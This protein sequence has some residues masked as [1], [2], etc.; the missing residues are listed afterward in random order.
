MDFCSWKTLSSMATPVLRK[1]L[2]LKLKVSYFNKISRKG[3]I[4][5]FLL[6]IAVSFVQERSQRGNKEVIVP[7]PE[8]SR[9]DPQTFPFLFNWLS[10]L[11]PLRGIKPGCD[12]EFFL[13]SRKVNDT[14]TGDFFL[15]K[16][17]L[18][19]ISWPPEV[20]V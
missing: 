12:P 6:K 11:L 3:Q 17:C 16:T 15:F 13:H 1:H 14:T 4:Q 7:S 18:K 20:L 2:N 19:V 8:I 9:L 10:L 5:I